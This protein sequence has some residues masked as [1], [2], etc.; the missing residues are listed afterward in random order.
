MAQPPSPLMRPGLPGGPPELGD[1][2][3]ANRRVPHVPF[4][5]QLPTAPGP[6]PPPATKLPSVTDDP[7]V[8]GE[9]PPK[10]PDL[11][12]YLNPALNQ[13]KSDLAGYQKADEANRID[14][15]K[16]KPRLWE[17]LVGFGLGATQLKDPQNAGAVA[18]EVVG[19][20]QAGAENARN[21]ALAPWTQRLE[22]DK[23]GVP[24][25]ESA[26]RTAHE[27]GELDLQRYNAITNSEYKE[28]IASIRD[29][30]AKGNIE[31]AENQL[32]QQQKALEEK[33]DRDADYFKMQ[34]ALLDLREHIADQKAAGGT[35]AKPTQ[36]A[37]AESKKASAL[38]KAKTVYDRETALAGTDPDARKTAEDNF[39]AAQQEAQDAYEAEI[40]SLGGEASHQD[41]S[42]WWGGTRAAQPAAAAPAATPSPNAK[43]ATTSSN[44]SQPGAGKIL[45]M[46]AIEQ[47]AQDNKISVD[48]AKQQAIAQGYKVQ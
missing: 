34:H 14:P 36:F 19:R 32:D 4:S 27:Q 43:P 12:S 2:P 26:A 8:R 44:T 13:Y 30:V 45:P 15:Q 40:N 48:E 25:A 39:H 21:L 23:A 35:K 37:G 24:L 38:E 47:A 16:V 17:R 6:L 1:V 42:S 5:P 9:Q 22:Q 3:L 41:V 28:A 33:K 18:S 46:S 11:G 20:R 7:N 29:E 31:K 10:T